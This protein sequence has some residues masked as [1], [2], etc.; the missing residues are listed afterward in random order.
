M[1]HGTWASA[2]GSDAARADSDA[3]GFPIEAS[4]HAHELLVPP[5]P[6]LALRKSAWEKALSERNSCTNT[7]QDWTLELNRTCS[8]DHEQHFDM[9]PSSQFLPQSQIPGLGSGLAHEKIAVFT[10]RSVPFGAIFGR[11]HRAWCC[12]GSY[13]QLGVHGDFS[14]HARPASH[15]S[16][17]DA[18][19]SGV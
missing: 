1:G 15:A 18:V 8:Y 11:N 6:R 13:G 17:H 7:S 14:R 9:L 4:L 19:V 5:S 2:D 12:W 10:L 3:F 16:A